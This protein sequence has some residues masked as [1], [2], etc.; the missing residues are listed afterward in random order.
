[1]YQTDHQRMHLGLTARGFWRMANGFYQ[2]ANGNS[3]ILGQ[4]TALQITDADGT[5]K[6]TSRDKY[7]LR[8]CGDLFFYNGIRIA[9]RDGKLSVED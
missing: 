1:M 3:A 7:F 2:H 8:E 6:A 5:R 4:R 9:R